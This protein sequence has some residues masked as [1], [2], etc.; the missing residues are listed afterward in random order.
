[1]FE[2]KIGD[3]NPA[4][5][6]AE[7]G[8]AKRII[9]NGLKIDEAMMGPKDTS[10]KKNARSLFLA[11]VVDLH[12]IMTVGDAPMQ[13]STHVEADGKVVKDRFGVTPFGIRAY[14]MGVLPQALAAGFMAY[15]MLTHECYTAM[16]Y[17]DVPM[18]WMLFN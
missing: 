2:M 1:M 17:P 7:L 13:K 9:E 4:S 11:H 6:D 8:K 16:W 12:L 5:S 15:V 10:K 14:M 3:S 18:D